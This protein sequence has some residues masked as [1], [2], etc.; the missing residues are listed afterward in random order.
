MLVSVLLVTPVLISISTEAQKVQINFGTVT[1]E[2]DRLNSP[3]PHYSLN[4]K[5]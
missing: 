5:I 2:R 4:K 3:I 1:C